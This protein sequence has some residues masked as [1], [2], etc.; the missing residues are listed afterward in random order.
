MN[1]FHYFS[2]FIVEFE[3]TPELK[4]KLSSTSILVRFLLL[5][6][7]LIILLAWCF[8]N[9]L[10]NYKYLLCK[11]V[12]CSFNILFSCCIC[13]KI[14]LST[15]VLPDAVYIG[16]LRKRNNSKGR[17]KPSRAYDLD[18]LCQGTSVEK[19]NIFLFF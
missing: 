6:V 15:K 16:H 18:N 9:W 10:W 1:I 12:T 8:N 11:S 19:E 5:L 14:A 3:L 7:L 13:L 2:Y 4:S 17:S